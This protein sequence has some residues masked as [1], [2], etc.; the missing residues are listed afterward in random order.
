MVERSLIENA[1]PKAN[2]R[3][4]RQIEM[5]KIVSRKLVG[6]QPVYDLGVVEDHNFLLA[7]GTVASNC[8]NKS[9]STAYAYVTYQTAYLKANYPTE[10][11]AAL[12]T[13]SS[14]NQDKIEK[15]RENCLKLSIEVFPPDINRSQADFL[16]QGKMKILFGLAA[17]RNLGQGAIEN[18]LAARKAAG[19]AFQSFADFCLQVDLRVV[20]RK[21]IETLILAGAFDRIQNN[22]RQLIE[23]LEPLIN[24]AQHKTKEKNIGQLNLFD[25]ADN[26]DEAKDEAP[27]DAPSA[28]PVA[29]YSLQEKLKLE[30]EHIGFYLSEHPLKS[31]TSAA[32]ILSPINLSELPQLKQKQRVSAV[33][34]LNSV[35]KHINSKG[36]PMAF[37]QLED[38]S[39]EAEAVVFSDLYPKI[40]DFLVEDARLL[41]WA[42]TQKRDD[43]MQLIID[44]A[45]PI[46]N[47]KMILLEL[48]PQQAIDTSTVTRLKTLLQHKSHQSS[49]AIPVIIVLKTG[50]ERQFIRLGESFWVKNA[51]IAL[52]RLQ[53]AGFNA[54]C[55][56]LIRS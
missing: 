34:M 52:D 40:K 36:Q 3:S 4:D 51:D 30:K 18:I 46:E 37:V 12:L 29:D 56:Q 35:R 55:Q 53:K 21:A 28:P 45:E 42:K 22:R 16:P 17:V 44:D 24:W 11:M 50:H 8:F 27:Q 2:Q 1:M 47:L 14:N 48:L 43:K 32:Q 15:Y 26:Q 20:N 39:S 19:G 54:Y 9:H 6:K 23:N 41:I 13:S 7:N 31:V 5:V 38:V 25:S 33:V 10:Y 49:S